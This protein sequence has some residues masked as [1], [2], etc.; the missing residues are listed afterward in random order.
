MTADDQA[1]LV[2]LIAQA[3]AYA[4]NPLHAQIR[5]LRAKVL[6]LEAR[7]A[8]EDR[9]VWQAGVTY[10]HGHVVTCDGSLWLAQRPTTARPGSDAGAHDWRLCV[11]RGRDGRDGRDRRS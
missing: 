8:L 11:K 9:G 5:D 7:P 10:A 1:A 4:T 2:E 6:A 3:V